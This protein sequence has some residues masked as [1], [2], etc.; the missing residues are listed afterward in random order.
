MGP[1]LSW[2]AGRVASGATV[3]TTHR[4]GSLR[5]GSDGPRRFRLGP[6]LE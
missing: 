4:A 3:D 5:G 1:V 6:V 2:A